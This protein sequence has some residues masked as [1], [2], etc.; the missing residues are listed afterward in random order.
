M[1]ALKSVNNVRILIWYK[2]S[3]NFT[4]SPDTRKNL[5]HV[6]WHCWSAADDCFAIVNRSNISYQLQMYFH[7]LLESE[8]PVDFAVSAYRCSHRSRKSSAPTTPEMS[9][10]G[11]TLALKCQRIVKSIGRITVLSCNKLILQFSAA[12]CPP[13]MVTLINDPTA[14]PTKCVPKLR[15]MNNQRTKRRRL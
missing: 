15:E 5:R 13:F 6:S 12:V 7:L 14:T 8:A 3:V 2:F 1:D 9:T 11:R 10:T 4:P